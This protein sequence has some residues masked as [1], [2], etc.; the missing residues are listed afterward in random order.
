VK[1]GKVALLNACA[2]V[3]DQGEKYCPEFEASEESDKQGLSSGCTNGCFLQSNA[4]LHATS[5]H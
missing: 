2:M 4:Y 5:F 3:M 1:V